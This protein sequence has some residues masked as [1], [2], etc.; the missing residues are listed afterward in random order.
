MRTLV[1]YTG[2]DRSSL[3][4][5]D[6]L[7]DAASAVLEASILGSASRG[8]TVPGDC[9]CDPVRVA[10]GLPLAFCTRQFATLWQ[11]LAVIQ[12]TELGQHIGSLIHRLLTVDR[13]LCGH[14][15]S[16]TAAIKDSKI[17]RR[18]ESGEP[19]AYD[20][21]K[22]IVVRKRHA[23]TNRDG[24]RLVVETI[25]ASLQDRNEAETLIRTLRCNFPSAGRIYAD[26]GNKG[27]QASVGTA[28]LSSYHPRYL[29]G[30]SARAYNQAIDHS[31]NVNLAGPQPTALQ[32]R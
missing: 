21:G 31:A 20:S 30:R 19:I 18:C 6:D 4:Y 9:Q 15:L 27:R 17:A 11:G 26:R 23:L 29:L 25:A 22:G 3:R 5:G 32:R 1:V 10:F 8:V 2:P 28:S 24:R 7:A 16:P 14:E 12:P 13:K